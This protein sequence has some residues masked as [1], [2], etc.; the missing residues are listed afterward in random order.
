MAGTRSLIASI[1]ACFIHCDEASLLWD[2]RKSA[3]KDIGW[4]QFSPADKAPFSAIPALLLSGA[5]DPSI[6]IS[7]RSPYPAF[8]VGVAQ[9][10]G[11]TGDLR[12]TF[13]AA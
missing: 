7:W 1:R 3:T 4:L 10:S 12:S 13:S 6:A 11:F 2:A 8:L 9:A 5:L